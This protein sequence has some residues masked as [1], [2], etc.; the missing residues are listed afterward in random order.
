[1][2]WDERMIGYPDFPAEDARCDFFSTL[3]KSHSTN[4][5]FF[6]NTAIDFRTIVGHL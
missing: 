5:T 6:L 1:M 4:H 3:D 2:L